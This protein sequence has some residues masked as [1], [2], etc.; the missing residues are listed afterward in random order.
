MA[1]KI[2]RLKK[3]DGTPDVEIIIGQAQWGSYDL[4]LWDEDGLN[5]ATIGSGLNVDQIP[6]KF[7]INKPLTQL[8][9][10]LLSWEVSIA[11]FAGKEGELYSVTIKITQN[12]A[13]VPGGEIVNSGGLSG[14]AFVND[15]VR[16]LV[17]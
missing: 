3:A 15:F 6:D 16:L 17:L 7:P 8:N 4:I 13:V 11:S 2:A 12:N 9:G 1:E 5:E 10:S 14:A